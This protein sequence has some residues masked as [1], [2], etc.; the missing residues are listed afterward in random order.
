MRCNWPPER[1]CRGLPVSAPTPS[2]SAASAASAGAWLPAS[3]SLPSRGNRPAAGFCGIHAQAR[4]RHA[5]S[6]GERPS[7]PPTRIEPAIWRCRP[8]T[9]RRRVDLPD[10]LVPV[11][12][13]RS[14]AAISR[15]TSATAS[16]RPCRQTTPRMRT[17]NPPITRP[18]IVSDCAG[19]RGSASH[20]PVVGRGASGVPAGPEP[21]APGRR[22]GARGVPG[23]LSDPPPACRFDHG[24]HLR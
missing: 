10:P 5:H 19:R 18:S 17:S 11:S 8:R 7:R 2:R 22:E 16:T 21:I 6:A 3:S 23:A 24:T 4:R 9:A 14:P 13:T 1:V 15:S 12:A 20:V